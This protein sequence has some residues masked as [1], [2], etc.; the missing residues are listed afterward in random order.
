MGDG[1]RAKYQDESELTFFDF[2]AREVNLCSM[3]D[4]ESKL[5][6][7]FG[8]LRDGP[9]PIN[10]EPAG[11]ELIALGERVRSGQQMSIPDWTTGG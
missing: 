9:T 7:I 10:H 8:I 4:W 6:D 11:D 1:C 3:H 2:G 5:Y